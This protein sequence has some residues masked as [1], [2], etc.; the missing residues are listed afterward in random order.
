MDA[1]SAL[2]SRVM[3][4]QPITMDEEQSHGVPVA[5][6]PS[7]LVPLVVAG[8]PVPP[9]SIAVH[10][11]CLL[12]RTG[13]AAL[14]LGG[15]PTVSR[16]HARLRR[17]S[18]GR[19]L[20]ETVSPVGVEVN[21]RPVERRVLAD[22]D[23]IGLGRSLLLARA[24]MEPADADVAG[25][26]GSAPSL[27]L[28]RSRLMDA[29]RAKNR[30]LLLGERGS[31]QA[32]AARALHRVRRREGRFVKWNCELFPADLQETALCSGALGEAARGTLYL[33]SVTHLTLAAQERLEWALRSG[34]DRDARVDALGAA[35]L[36]V[37]AVAT[38]YADVGEQV[39]AGTLRRSLFECL[40]ESVVHLPPLRDCRE[41]ILPQLATYLGGPL[42]PMTFG[43]LRAILLHPWPSNAAELPRF[44]ILLRLR[45]EETPHERLRLADFAERL[46]AVRLA[47][48]TSRES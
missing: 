14:G 24:P 9:Q 40:A 33:E 8:V 35:A 34:T 1:A 3:R 21:G 37:S 28:A 2:K 25:L 6:S 4:R 18:D 45:A 48:S 30:V 13:H 5:A 36:D 20:M 22:G 47:R 11:H 42:P 46:D 19:L 32:A 10:E 27:R 16:A 41:D 38:A 12:G 44:A 15:D 31:G 26:V 43:L 7:A 23:V 17:I 39:R 29:A